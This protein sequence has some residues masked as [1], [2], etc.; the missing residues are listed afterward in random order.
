MN[1]VQKRIRKAHKLVALETRL[2]E[3]AYDSKYGHKSYLYNTRQRQSINSRL[4][5]VTS[6][7]NRLVTILEGLGFSDRDIFQ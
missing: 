3:D 4:N 2:R 1:A 7:L 5:D 6:Q